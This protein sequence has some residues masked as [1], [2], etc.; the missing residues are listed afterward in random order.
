MLLREPLMRYI[1]ERLLQNRRVLNDPNESL[2]ERGV[3]DSIGL[4]NLITFLETETGIRVPEQE[5]VPENFDSVVS[6]EALVAKL[7]R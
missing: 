4:L 1:T 6:M 5:M 3:I 7:K 2:L